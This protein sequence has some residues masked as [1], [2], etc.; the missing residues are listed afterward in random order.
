MHVSGAD[1][2]AYEVPWPTKHGNYAGC[3]WREPDAPQIPD[4]TEPGWWGYSPKTGPQIRGRV[5][6]SRLSGS[7]ELDSWA[8]SPKAAKPAR[9][10]SDDRRARRRRPRKR[11]RKPHAH[12]SR[13]PY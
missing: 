5:P 8:Y 4:T 11:H 10:E 1:N 6:S 7:P 3:Q 2:A 9:P 13:A 12:T